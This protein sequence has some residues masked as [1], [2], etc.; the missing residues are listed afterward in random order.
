MIPNTFLIGAPKAGTSALA[1]YLSEHPDV[2]LGYPKE[3]SFWSSDL[4]S[5]NSVSLCKTLDDYL[6]LYSRAA[7]QKI[8]LD[9]STS[10]SYSDTAVSRILEF[11]STAKFIYIIRDPVELAH[12][13]HMEKVFNMVED[14]TN[15][16][17]AW[18]LQAIRREGIKI[19]SKC[20]EP[21]ELQYR[22][23]AA[24]GK[25]LK[26]LHQEIP[27]KQLLILFHDDMIVNT[28]SVYLEALAFLNLK[29]DNRLN[30]PKIGTAHF[31]RFSLLAKIYQTPPQAIAPAV[32]YTKM[33]IR[34]SPLSNTFK[35]MLI[36]R[37]KR[38]RLGANFAS[39]LKS[40]FSQEIDLIYEI[41]GRKLNEK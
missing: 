31:N 5:N 17:D 28:R 13:Y 32:R 34:Q 29:D 25:Q 11:Q 26:K 21:K 24:V 20:V 40:E 2:Y 37:R 30:F 38:P 22:E 15:F 36:D 18:N 33:L 10:Y 41:T 23:V 1:H 9:A 8:I 16:E 3:P 27:R 19:P 7:N 4:N 35:K 14:V 12:A 6:R 39:H